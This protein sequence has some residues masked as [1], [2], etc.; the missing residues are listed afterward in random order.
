MAII[1][2]TEI[3]SIGKDVEKK[4]PCALLVGIY[5]GS[6]VMKSSMRF[7]KILKVELPCDPTIPLVDIYPKEMKILPEKSYTKPYVHCSIITLAKIWK[8][9]MFTD[10]WMHEEKYMYTYIRWLPWWSSG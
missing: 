10:K 7:L 2:K 3:T 4:E 5:T 9:P 6:V 1:Q 8:Q